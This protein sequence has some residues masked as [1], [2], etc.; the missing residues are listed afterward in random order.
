MPTAKMGDLIAVS[1]LS[2]TITKGIVTITNLLKK[3]AKLF[4]LRILNFSTEDM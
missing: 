4:R 1:K 2:A 3:A